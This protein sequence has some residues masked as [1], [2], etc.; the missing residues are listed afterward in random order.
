ME[1]AANLGMLLGGLG[2]F[3][4]GCGAMWFISEW[5]KLKKKE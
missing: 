3:L 4:L 5:L 2:F 1:N